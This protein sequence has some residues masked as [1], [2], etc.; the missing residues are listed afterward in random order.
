M[1]K[2]IAIIDCATKTPAFSSFNKLVFEFPYQFTY[3]LPSI[4]GFSSLDY[5]E[6]ACVYIL[7][8]SSSNVTENLPW[9]HE[10]ASRMKKKIENGVP[11]LGICFGHQLMAHAYGALVD[12]RSEDK[13]SLKGTRKIQI[14]NER[15]HFKKGNS[16]NLVVAHAQEVKTLPECFDHIAA[17]SECFYDVVAHKKWPYL[18]CQAHPEASDAFIKEVVNMDNCPH[19]GHSFLSSFFNGR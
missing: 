6:D 15:Y 4:Y 19:E 7:F 13:T 9:H 3:H 10:L 18:G 17:S 1:K 14:I 16:F 12:Y 11:V 5:D 2:H 8:G